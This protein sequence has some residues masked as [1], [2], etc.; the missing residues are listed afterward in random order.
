MDVQKTEFD[1]PFTKEALVTYATEGDMAWVNQ[2]GEN[3]RPKY[4]ERLNKN[5]L[6]VYDV[7]KIWN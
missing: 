2:Q 3:F 1:V 5:V 6:L 4:I 7:A